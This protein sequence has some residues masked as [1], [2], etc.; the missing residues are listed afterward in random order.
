MKYLKFISI[1][2]AILFLLGTAFYAYMGGF[3]RVEVKRD[4]FGPISIFVY[5]HKGPYQNLNQSWEKFQKE[6]EAIGLTECSSLAI[7]L[8]S[9]DTPEEKLRSV[10]ACKMDGLSELE[11]KAVEKQFVT[12]VIPKS[13]VLVAS[14]PF[15]NVLSYFLAPTKVYPKFQEIISENKEQTSVSIEVYGGSLHFVDTIEFYMPLGIG[16]EV[17]SPLEKL[18]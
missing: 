14:F 12:F 10:L 13:N 11:K 6:W 17:F 5:P 8:D 18:F 1:I 15:R 4:T 3:S 2:I 16:R 9:P 7:Y